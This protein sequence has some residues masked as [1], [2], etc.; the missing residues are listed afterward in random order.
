MKKIY[1]PHLNIIVLLLI[2]LLFPQLISGQGEIP[3]N[4]YDLSLEELMNL[5][6]VTA[7]KLEENLFDAPATMIVITDEQIKERGYLYFDEVLRDIPGFDLVHVW[8]TFP[9]IWAQRGL[10]GA[11]GKRTI[12]M[13]DGIVENNILEGNVL[14]GPQYSLH[15]VK[16]IEII[17]GPASALYGANA[18]SGII[19]IVTKQGSDINHLEFSQGIGSFN[20][21]YETFIGGYSTLDYDLIVS[22][23][24]YNTNGPVFK[25]R[26]PEYNNSY[27]ENAY[28]I[29]IKSRYK[30]FK[31]GFYRY[32]RPMGDGQFSNSP[33]VNGYGLPP[34]GYENSEGT[35]GGEAQTDIMGQKGSKWHSI[36]QTAFLSYQN[37]SEKSGLNWKIYSRYTAIDDDSEIFEY[38]MEK[39]EFVKLL[40]FHQS[41]LHGLETQYY[42][43][44]SNSTITAGFQYTLSDVEKGYR[45]TDSLADGSP[46]FVD[47]D[48]RNS[49]IYHNLGLYAQYW[50]N[51][52][53]LQSA[54]FI[55]GLRYDMNN[56]FPNSLNPRAGLV[57]KATDKINVKLLFGKAYRTPNNFELYS[58]TTI[59][60]PN[61]DLESE[62]ATSTSIDLDLCPTKSWLLRTSVFANYYEDLIV[63]NVNIGDIDGDGDENTQNINIGKAKTAGI[64]FKI[65]YI[66]KHSDIFFNFTWQQGEQNDGNGYYDIPNTAE[67]KWNTGITYRHPLLGSIYA[68]GNYVGSRS[69]SLT[70]PVKSIDG[71]FVVNLNYNSKKLYNSLFSFQLRID[72]L[73]DANYTDPG[74][75]SASGKYYGTRHLQPG[76]I[77]SCNL[78]FDL[79]IL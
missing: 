48:E 59:R 52:D 41:Y 5:K 3:E 42:Y 21:I 34:Y 4:Y 27:V 28:S 17:W 1:F 57:I 64:E 45:G 74:I 9:T 32:D 24:L 60:I 18:Y 29:F 50:Y 13:I 70:N 7:S 22:G 56:M 54:A 12:V 26:H 33:A 25:E 49:V 38:S 65:D 30:K 77:I 40:S 76:R 63:S 58:K 35:D 44:T 55:S 31:F 23:S 71:Y 72:N 19:N 75:R 15:N 47:E 10:Y 14:G 51:F 68:V 78:Q 39:D 36:T 16:R 46:V 66:N 53:F 61:P 37:H 79:D 69:T 20:T 62:K 2:T 8:G 6:V 67:F 43:N 73:F 11:E